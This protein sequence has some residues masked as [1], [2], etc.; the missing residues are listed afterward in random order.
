MLL[1]SKI[2]EVADGDRK[3]DLILITGTEDVDTQGA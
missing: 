3:M 1:L 2:L